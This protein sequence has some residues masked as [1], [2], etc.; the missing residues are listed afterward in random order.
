[1][2][3]KN[4]GQIPFDDDGIDNILQAI[5]SL[6]KTLP[7]DG[8]TDYKA[9]YYGIFSGISLIIENTTTYEQTID[10]LKVLQCKAEDFYI[11][12]G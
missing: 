5:L 7:G 10:A 8:G 12:Q 1:M 2:I 9:L 3:N 11:S 6:G 4:E